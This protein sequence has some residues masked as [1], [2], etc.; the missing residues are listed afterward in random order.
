MG[1]KFKVMWIATLDN[2]T[3]HE[4]RLLDGQMQEVDEPFHVGGI[5]IMYPA[6]YGGKDYKVPPDMIYN[7]RCSIGAA[8]KG[9]R[10]YDEGI[11]AAN[12]EVGTGQTYEEWKY[13]KAKQPKPQK[14]PSIPRN[15]NSEVKKR[16]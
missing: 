10:L 8:V 9:T 6:D 3:R 16:R 15:V 14:T 11:G 1:V 5:E 7:C 2:R 4:H 13:A 12:R